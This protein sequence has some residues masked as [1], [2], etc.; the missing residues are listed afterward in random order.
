MPWKR[1]TT[2]ICKLAVLEDEESLAL[3]NLT[4]SLCGPVRPVG[5][6]VA[7]CLKEADGV[8]HILGN[9]QQLSRRLDVSREAEVCL[10]D[11]DQAQQI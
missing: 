8:A 2:N 11:R 6:D 5:D 10:L 7:V 1:R 4:Q 3:G 9:L